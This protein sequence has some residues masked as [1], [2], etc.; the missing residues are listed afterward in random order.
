[1]CSGNTTERSDPKRDGTARKLGKEAYQLP[2][3][4]GR[5]L[6]VPDTERANSYPLG[7]VIPYR[8]GN[9]RVGLKAKD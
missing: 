3:L 6:T 7:D 4:V 8:K 5:D 9:Q 1:V 2:M